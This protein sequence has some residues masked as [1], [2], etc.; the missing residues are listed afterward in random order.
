MAIGLHK[1]LRIWGESVKL[2]KKVYAIADKMPSSEEYNL[3]QQIK[4]AVVSGSLNIAEG[5]NR[6]TRKEFL[7]FMNISYASLCEVDA[8]L[9]ICKDLGYIGNDEEVKLEIQSLGKMMNALRSK[10]YRDEK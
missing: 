9:D 10:L 7:N 4:R 2:I 1:D 5:R 8:I 3:K 6:K